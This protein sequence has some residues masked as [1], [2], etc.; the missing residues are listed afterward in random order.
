MP[1][2]ATYFNERE[3]QIC[4][5]ARMVEDARTYWVAGGGSP[6]ASILLAKKLY[7]HN[8]VY[9]TEDGVVDPEPMLPLDPLMTMVSSRASYRALQWGTMN[10][11]GFQAQIGLMD[12]GLLNTLQV[13]PY[14]NINS[15]ALGDYN[16][17]HRR[18]GGPGGADSIAALCWKTILMTD[19]QKR[20]FVPRVD[21]ISSPGFLDGTEGARERAGLPRGT[22]PYRCVTPWA[23]FDYEDRYM[24]L[25]GISPFVT[26]EQVLAEM[27]FEPKLAPQIET[28]VTPTEE[29]LAILRSELDQRGQITDV[30]K[31]VIRL[32]D[33]TFQFVEEE[34]TAKDMPSSW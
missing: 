1:T 29:E 30:G 22:G 18:F 28:L 15:T 8:A 32:D 9:V 19:Q 17:E 10:S 20:K 12:Y 7:A 27:S 3:H 4:L 25:I 31:P 23:V 21:F 34:K 16:G 5:V 33:G 14:G 11:V 2:P 13:D 24:R 6:M 26:K